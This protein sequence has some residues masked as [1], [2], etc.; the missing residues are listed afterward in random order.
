MVTRANILRTVAR[1]AHEARPASAG[2]T[3]IRKRL[4]EELNKLPWTPPV[5]VAVKDGVVKLSGVLTD[6]RQRAAL[7]VAAENIPGV[8]NVTDDLIWIDPQSGMTLP[9]VP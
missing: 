9:P 3:E 1:L 2:D 5:S 8:K 6:E 4:V 7:R